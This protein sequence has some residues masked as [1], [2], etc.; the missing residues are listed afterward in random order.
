MLSFKQWLKVR[1]GI[2]VQ[3]GGGYN[4]VGF[5]TQNDRPYADIKSKFH[6]MDNNPEDAKDD[7]DRMKKAGKDLQ[8]PNR[9][10]G[11]GPGDPLLR[12][13]KQKMHKDRPR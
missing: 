3:Y 13:Q 5:D 9:L 6:T 4:P 2:A 7:I 12:M 1:E 10:F 8:M 11:F